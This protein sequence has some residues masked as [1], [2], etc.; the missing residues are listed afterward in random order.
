M[1]NGQL[2]ALDQVETGLR[3]LEIKLDPPGDDLTLV[4]DK[5]IQDLFE[6]QLLGYVLAFIRDQGQHIGPKGILELGVA[7]KLVEDHHRSGIATQ[8]HHN[9]DSIVAI[10]LIAD[11]RD[12]FNPFILDQVGDPLDQAGLVNHVRQGLDDDPVS[13][14]GHLLNIGMAPDHDPSPAPPVG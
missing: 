13:V 10:G 14:V 4:A 3:P 6:L 11:I 5:V 12:A 9:P 1:V 2:Q 7:V 8:F